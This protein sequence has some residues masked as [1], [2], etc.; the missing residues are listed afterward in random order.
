[1]WRKEEE[2]VEAEKEEE[3]EEEECDSRVRC[4][5]VRSRINTQDEGNACR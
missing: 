4:F 2:E 3:E 1:M 5:I